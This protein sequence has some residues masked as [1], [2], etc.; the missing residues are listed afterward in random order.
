MGFPYDTA[1]W[2]AVDGAMFMGWGSSMPATYT[3]IAM[4]LCAVVLLMG[5]SSE[6]KQYKKAE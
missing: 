6:H 2:S 1:S 4:I 3:V 5:N